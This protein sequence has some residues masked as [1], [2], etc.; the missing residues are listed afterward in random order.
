MSIN[1]ASS[2]NQTHPSFF[3]LTKEQFPCTPTCNYSAPSTNPKAEI[4]STFFDLES[5][6][7]NPE[8]ICPKSPDGNETL[9]RLECQIEAC[10]SLRTTIFYSEMKRCF[11]DTCNSTVDE[12][13]SYHNQLLST[14]KVIN[15]T[16]RDQCRDAGVALGPQASEN[17]RL[18]SKEEW[19]DCEGGYRELSRCDKHTFSGSPVG[20][21]MSRKGGLL[22][23]AVLLGGY[24]VML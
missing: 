23:A 22:I 6:S 5:N 12:E 24:F 20:V 16:V 19:E 7:W 1:S 14:F 8:I 17:R 11:M 18:F 15:E 2:F 13:Y 4:R 21:D 10:L 9:A 3:N